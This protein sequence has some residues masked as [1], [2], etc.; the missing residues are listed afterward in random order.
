MLA[1]FEKLTNKSLAII[2]QKTYALA[3]GDEALIFVHQLLDQ[4]VN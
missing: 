2:P 4:I 1:N 3:K